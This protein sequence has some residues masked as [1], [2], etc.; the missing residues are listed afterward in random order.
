MTGGGPPL[1]VW[2]IDLR[3]CAPALQKL[4]LTAPRLSDDEIARARAKGADGASWRAK[5]IALRLLLERHAGPQVRQQAFV[6]GAQGKPQLAWPSDIHF[7]VSDS[8][9]FAL[10]AIARGSA[11]GVDMEQP[12]TMRFSDVR[13][14]ALVSAAAGVGQAGPEH[15]GFEQPGLG[16][17]GLW[18]SGIAG[19]PQDDA[20]VL[21]AWVRLEAWAKARGTGIGAL[22]TDLGIWGAAYVRGSGGP[23]G[24][25]AMKAAQQ[26]GI[27]VLD[28]ELPHNLQGAV[29]CALP[30]APVRVR[31]F[32]D[33]MEDL[34]ALAGPQLSSG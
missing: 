19:D 31:E 15:S 25:R 20:T 13:R 27:Q 8:G 14:V 17:S 10:L 23:P 18:P 24:V 11:V 5:R 1:E 6:T 32:P 9:P 30:Y 3:R 34:G 22:L 21:Q 28:L 16:Q 29:A 7:S 2:L 26:D 12:R 4:E 33:D